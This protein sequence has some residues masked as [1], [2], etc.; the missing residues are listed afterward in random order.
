MIVEAVFMERRKEINNIL[1]SVKAKEMTD[2]EWEFFQDLNSPMFDVIN[3]TKT[4]IEGRSAFNDVGESL[5][6]ISKFKLIR[7]E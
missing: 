7:T 6:L 1:I 2:R 3:I 5:D 4:L